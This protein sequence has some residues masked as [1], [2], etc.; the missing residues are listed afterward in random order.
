MVKH[1]KRN[2]H[3]VNLFKKNNKTFANAH[4]LNEGGFGFI[5]KAYHKPS[6]Q[7]VVVKILSLEDKDE[8]LARKVFINEIKTLESL[9]HPNIVP[10]LYSNKKL[11][12]FA[13]PYAFGGNLANFVQQLTWSKQQVE[14]S[15]CHVFI[16]LVNAVCYLHENGVIHN[17]IKTDNVLMMTVGSLPDVNLTDFDS[18]FRIDDPEESS[19]YPGTWLH[20]APEQVRNLKIRHS[21]G[22]HGGGAGG[23]GDAADDD[24]D[25]KHFHPCTT[26]VDIYSIG[27]CLYESMKRDYWNNLD[28]T[29]SKVLERMKSNR[30]VENLVSGLKYR[31]IFSKNMYC[32]LKKCLKFDKDDRATADGLR[33]HQWFQNQ[34]TK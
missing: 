19:F 1:A 21:L 20:A 16:Q 24:N 29:K 3:Y 25:N 23:G 30:F 12:H 17:D 14:L 6:N 33:C 4:Y 31:N 26:A 15:L 10:I 18:S 2:D 27:L 11:L 32:F 34:K 7:E 5:Y 8:K 13:L 28:E 9:S 22:D